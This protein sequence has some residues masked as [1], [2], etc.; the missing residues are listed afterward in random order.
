MPNGR[1]SEPK[2]EF[3][4]RELG[5]AQRWREGHAQCPC[6]AGSEFQLVNVESE[7]RMRYESFRCRDVTCDALWKVEFCES[8][9]AI[10]REGLEQEWIEL[11]S[12]TDLEGRQ[13]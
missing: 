13:S 1:Q 3:R 12:M 9:I 2:R 6:Y 10:V 8:A 11:L 5:W 4:R 7:G